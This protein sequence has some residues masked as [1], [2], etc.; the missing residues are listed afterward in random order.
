MTTTE[1]KLATKLSTYSS[2]EMKEFCKTEEL[3]TLHQLKLYL[4]DFYYNT[5]TSILS[6]ELYDVL[7]RFLVKNDKG[8][9]TPVGSKVRWAENRV[10]LPWWMGSV[11]TFTAED[12]KKIIKR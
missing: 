6:N 8:Y 2:K 11:D 3:S 4:H 7:K 1:P 12:S 5:S 9:I 10:E